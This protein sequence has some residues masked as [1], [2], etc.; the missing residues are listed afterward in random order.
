VA[1]DDASRLAYTELLAN[2]R[3]ESA[4]AFTRRA[5]AWF[6][7]HGVSVERLRSDNDSAY[8]SFAFRDLL[9]AQAIKHKRTKPYT[10]RTNGKA[11]RF[12]QTSLR[13]WAYAPP[14]QT[15]AKRA[16]AMRPWSADYNHSRPHSALGGDP[17]MSRIIRSPPAAS[18]SAPES[19]PEPPFGRVAGVKPRA[20]IAEGGPRLTPLV[21]PQAQ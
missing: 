11:E 12:I 17:P 9:A 16:A 5:L 1:V 4:V 14:F 3:K 15:S 19:D 20:A 13:D 21:R 18:P 10:P 6:G 7:R 8:R 2:A